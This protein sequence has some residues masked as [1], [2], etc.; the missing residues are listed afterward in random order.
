MR[1]LTICGAILLAVA[2]L[3]PI[4]AA[5]KGPPGN[6]GG[7]SSGSNH[8][9]WNPSWHSDHDYGHYGYYGYYR[10]TPYVVQRP[11]YENP[12]FSGLPIKITNPAANG[13]ALS[14]TLNGVVYSI[15]PGYSQDL[16]ED[17]SWVIDFSRGADMGVARYSLEPGIY[18]FA[19]SGRGW[20]LF[21]RPLV[22]PGTVDVP[23]NPAP[24]TL[25]P[26]NPAPKPTTAPQP[27]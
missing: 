27:H 13:V 2:A 4:D 24:P 6:N 7:N 25:P 1:Y 16:V 15:P 5:A 12:S 17:R 26:A 9:G 8:G 23:T 20:E 3:S 19:H 22:Q 11:I 18:S 21:R 10:D 14:Y